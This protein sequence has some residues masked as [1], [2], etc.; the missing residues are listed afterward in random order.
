[1][2]HFEQGVEDL[3]TGVAPRVGRT[4]L[5]ASAVALMLAASFAACGSDSS[6]DT[7]TSASSGT[8]A[9][10]SQAT[11]TTTTASDASNGVADK[12]ADE[13]LAAAKE[14]ARGASAVHV[15]GDAD[16][17][18]LD[19]SLVKG[20]GASGSIEQGTSRFELIT[21]GDEIFL[22]GSDEFYRGLGGESV[23]RLLSGKWL[24]VPSTTR[25]FES[26]AAITDM[27]TLLTQ[28]LRP[29]SDTI[30]KGEA[31]TIDGTEVIGLGGRRG[32][33]YVATTGEP[34]PVKIAS[35]DDTGSVR[36]DGW[37]EPVDLTAPTD[38]IDIDELQRAGTQTTG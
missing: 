8:T 15:A 2:G 23:V 38:A 28:T 16:G 25:G 26:F 27:D 29:D 31:E 22:R 1:M 35:S 19:L 11:Q 13:I 20:K 34:F 5:G 14:A 32:T 17:V 9:A 4:R 36:F 24:K 7:T 30:E 21:I 6:S 10:Q 3:K 33:L 37:N 18:V 12:S